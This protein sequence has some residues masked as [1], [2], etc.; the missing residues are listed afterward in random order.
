MLIV[1]RKRAFAITAVKSVR[2]RQAQV[3]LWKVNTDL[4]SRAGELTKDDMDLYAEPM[5]DIRDG[6]KYSQVLSNGLDNKLH[7][8]LKRLKK[9]WSHIGLHHFW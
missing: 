9:I 8:D 4:T 2:Q 1:G 5:P 7:E 6:K 3:V